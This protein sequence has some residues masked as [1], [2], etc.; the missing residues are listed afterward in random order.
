MLLASRQA[1]LEFEV[2][3]TFAWP[4]T[5]FVTVR[6]HDRVIVQDDANLGS[7]LLRTITT[8]IGEWDSEIEFRVSRCRLRAHAVDRNGVVLVDAKLRLAL[9]ANRNVLFRESH[10]V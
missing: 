2:S 10:N 1:D 6:V 9:Q 5:V 7:A 4:L 8:T 3:N